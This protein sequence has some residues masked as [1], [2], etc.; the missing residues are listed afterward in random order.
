MCS[1]GAFFVYPAWAILYQS[2]LPFQVDDPFWERLIVGFYSLCIFSFTLIPRLMPYMLPATY[3]AIYISV[4]HLYWLTYR[5]GVHPGYQMGILTIIS[6]IAPYFFSLGSM[7]AFMSF[8]VL[9]SLGM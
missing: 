5:N 1:V 8:V 6:A 4:A 2:V 7:F 9:L 3:S